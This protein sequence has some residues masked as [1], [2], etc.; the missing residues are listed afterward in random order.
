[1]L[2]KKKK[3]K[4]K[5]THATYWADSLL[6]KSKLFKAGKISLAEYIL[7]VRAVRE[8]K[9]LAIVDAAVGHQTF[10]KDEVLSKKLTTIDVK[11][12]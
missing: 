12:L 1:M 6:E 2:S 5:V 9:N 10:L 11:E 3:V 7:E 8:I 4:V